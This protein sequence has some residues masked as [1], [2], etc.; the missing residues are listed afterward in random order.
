MN[1][2]DRVRARSFGAVAQNY[3][4]Y[5]PRYPDQLVDDVVAM[6][7]GRRVLEVGAGTGIATAAFAARGMTMTCVE[8]DPQ[9]AAVLSAKLAG[10]SGHTVRVGTFEEWSGS[11][12]DGLISAQ[13]WHWTDPATRWANAAAALRGGGVLALFWNQNRHADPRV[14]DAFQA[15]YD[16]HGIEVRTVRPPSRLDAEPHEEMATGGGHFDDVRTHLYHWTRRVPV[17]D[18]LA[19][20]NTSSAHLILPPEIR[21]SLTAELLTTLTSQGDGVELAMVTDLTTAVRPSTT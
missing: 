7:P 1:D 19:D 2:V 13:A 12:F 10:D 11:G 8:P 18:Y 20:I 5:R 4:R 16:R 3:D 17:A 21:D 14:D 6:L 9:M 15:A